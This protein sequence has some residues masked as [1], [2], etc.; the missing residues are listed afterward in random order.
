[1]FAVKNPHARTGSSA[2]SPQ[3]RRLGLAHWAGLVLSLCLAACGGGGGGS[4]PSLSTPASPSSPQPSPQPI[5]SATTTFGLTLPRQGLVAADLGV[6]VAE[7]DPL[8][9]AVAAYYQ[10][11]RGIP[12]AN[13]IRV[14]V[15]TASASIS[16]ADFAAL[17]TDVDAKLPA[18]VQATL[19]TWA[20]PSRV[21]GRC[22]MSITSALALGYDVQYCGGCDGTT[23]TGYFES[24]SQRP[25]TDLKLRP[26]MLLGASTL[27][28]AK[29]LIDRG[30]K[31]DASYP[32]GDG[33]LI[34][35]S[36]AARS[37][38]YAD[39]AAQPAAWA[40]RLQL[41]YIDASANS[42]N[43]AISGKSNV[44][45]YFTG[46]ASVPG[47]ASNGFRPGAVADHLTSY[48]GL[49]PGGGQMSA[50]DW[51]SAGATGSYG[52]VEEPCNYTNK[53]PQASSLIDQYYRGATLIEAYWKSVDWPG[54]GLFVGEPL[55]QPFADKPSFSLVGNQ[56]QI[57]TRALRPHSSYAL[58]YRVGSSG[59]WTSL[60]TFA[61][62][63]VPA[64]TLSSPLPP[65]NATQLR[66]MGPCGSNPL[67]QCMLSI[68]N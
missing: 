57:V 13:I 39:F 28:A 33:Y 65:A 60:A 10:T 27:D 40:G 6:I 12:A 29:A 59:S 18:G 17:K 63:A 53:F 3:A 45:F 37:V 14:K 52:T 20:A 9:E 34:R 24:E 64:Q 15:N 31:A 22:A 50:L 23:R 7:G 51:L 4:S 8:S 49:L 43:N 1:M 38:R 56:Y 61:T 47:I 48:G 58:E 5:G 44:L 67:L 2:A 11:A 68:S 66:W 19:V 25:W 41:S 16:A 36:D 46:L 42:A 30:V 21:V 32:T 54:Q 35:T 62:G 26:S 55:A